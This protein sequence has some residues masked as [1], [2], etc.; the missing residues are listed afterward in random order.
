MGGSG[1]PCLFHEPLSPSHRRVPFRRG[2]RLCRA[3]PRRGRTPVPGVA[4]PPTSGRRPSAAG[5]DAA[6]LRAAFSG[7][8][9][10]WSLPDLQPPGVPVTPPKVEWQREFGSP[11]PYFGEKNL[12]A[13]AAGVRARMK[14][15]GKTLA[16]VERQTGVPRGDHPRHLGPGDRLRRGAVA[17][18]RHPHH[19]HAGVHG[20]PQGR[21]PPRADRG[22]ANPAASRH[23]S[24]GPP[25]IGRRRA[26]PAAIPA[27]ASS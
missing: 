11:G 27:D 2:T 24:G 26:R 1:R 15:W 16:A 9:L 21:V 20:A 13:L 7:L 17:E 23:R 4:L 18:A 12:R 3:R 6:T 25:L 22:A 5:I 10:D 19:R 14:T 8:T